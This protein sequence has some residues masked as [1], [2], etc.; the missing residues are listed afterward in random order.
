MGVAEIEEALRVEVLEV[1]RFYCLQ[2][3]NEA[4]DQAR[5]ET[6]SALKRAKSVHYLPTIRASGSSGFKADTASKEANEGKES[7]TKALPTANIPPKKA[8]QSKVVEKAAD[9][10]KEVAH[11]AT[12]PPIAL[13]DPPKEKEPS[14]NMEIMLAT[15]PMPTKEDL[16]GE[17]QA[18]FT[19][20]ST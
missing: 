2:V 8:E 17:G 18:P 11:D 6:S 15:L 13:K 14:H 1:C 16:K 5:V 12:L 10:S 9:T 7:L 4:F 3:W 19:A 20:A